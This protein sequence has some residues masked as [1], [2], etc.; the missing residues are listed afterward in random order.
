[1]FAR[2]RLSRSRRV[3]PATFRRLIAEHGD[4]VRALAALPG[5][6]ADAGDDRYRPA[7]EAEIRREIAA[8]RKA[9]AKL[10]TLG[11]PG[12]PR[13]LAEVTDAPPVLWAQGNTAMLNKRCVAV[14][15][16][17]NASS[18]ALRMTRALGR[19]LADAG[20]IVVSGLAKGVDTVAHASALEGG[21]I[22]VHA[23][24]LDR[25][26]PAENAE[27]AKQIAERGCALSER[28]FG[29]SPQARDFPRRNRIVSG[30]SLAVVVVEAAARSGSMI[31][32]RDALDQGREVMAVPGHPMD[33]RASGC[34]NLLRDG[35][36]L[37][38]NVDDILDVLS[39]DPHPE[40]V[41]QMPQDTPP[42]VATDDLEARILTLLSPTPVGEDQLLRDLSAAGAIEAQT[43]AAH[44]SEMELAGAVG[45]RPGGGLVRL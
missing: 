29:L 13:R 14:V 44:L 3:G 23:G 20:I 41:A 5:I 11:A 30:L 31:T 42:P 8:A 16:T 32:A 21:T 19:D 33:G 12:Y 10:L 9:G 36:T 18:L 28:P 22:A 6:A 37:V 1:M 7:E 40:H 27:L 34:N 24:G 38:R 2:L 4:G 43:L 15:G 26:Y 25:I 45:R 35:A 17:R 39:E